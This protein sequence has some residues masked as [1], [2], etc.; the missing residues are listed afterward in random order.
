MRAPLKITMRHIPK[1]DALEARIRRRATELEEACPDITGCQVTIEELR[2]H[3][4]QGACFNARIDVR[5]PGHD[6]VV[7]RDHAEDAH[8]A[9]RDA[10]DAVTRRL[11]E[12]ARTRRGDVK[13]HAAQRRGA[14][15]GDLSQARPTPGRTTVAPND[16]YEDALPG[17]LLFEDGEPPA[18]EEAEGAVDDWPTIDGEQENVIAEP[19][20]TGGRHRR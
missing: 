19:A 18:A 11:E 17:S 7:N 4:G 16:E 1:S 9:V 13:T 3:R 12:V 2:G 6:I 15:A 8:V 20:A 5:V 10:F 14:H